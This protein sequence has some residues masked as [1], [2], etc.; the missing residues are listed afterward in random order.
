MDG[1]LFS[2]KGTHILISACVFCSDLGD[3]KLAV[4]YQKYEWPSR[5]MLCFVNFC[6]AAMSKIGYDF[7]NKVFQKLKLKLFFNQKWSPKLIFLNERQI[8]FLT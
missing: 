8:W 1:V 5:K 2:K 4:I 3:P 6:N 7:S